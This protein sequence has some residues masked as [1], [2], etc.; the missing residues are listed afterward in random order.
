MRF[1]LAFAGMLLSTALA[2]SAQ[3]APSATQGGVPLSVGF[4]YSNFYTDWSGRES[5]LTL[6]IDWNRLPLPR[7]L[8]GLGIEVEG[9]D[10]FF[11]KTGDNA[12][13]KEYTAGG[14]PIYHWRH[15]RRTDLFAKFLI[16]NG[17]IEFSNVPGDTYT[18]DS[19]TDYAPGGGASYR[20]WRN[21]SV[22]GDYEYQ[23][24]PDFLRHHAFNPDGFTVG[25]DYELGRGYSH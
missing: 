13:L 23:I 2:A 20:A 4:G 11:G 9:R 19:R 25:V 1:K 18:H 7:P 14:G 12:N 10:L 24:W 15:F 17:W 8:Q 21:I 3:I 22:R 6:W 16:S 5:G